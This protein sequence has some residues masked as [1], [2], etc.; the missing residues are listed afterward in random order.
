[1]TTTTAS[2][3]L[4]AANLDRSLKRTS[5]RPDVAR[6]SKYY[7]ANINKVKTVDD[8]LKNDRL[9]RF[10]MEAFGMSDMINSKAF[11]RKVLKEGTD[12]PKA[13]ANTLADGRYKE[14]AATFNF[15]RYASAT[16]AFDRVQQGTVDRY[17]RQQMEAQA[18]TQNEGVRLALY[19]ARKA[20]TLTSTY[21]ILAD[22]ALIKV[23]QTALD[24]PPETSM[25]RIEKQATMIEQ[26]LKIADFKDTAKLQ[27]FLDRFTSAWDIAND[28]SATASAAA[29]LG[30]STSFGV[31]SDVLASLQNLK[32]G[33]S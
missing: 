25:L 20:P 19:F 3:R 22:K 2:Y 5:T 10:A 30:G 26:R 32:L 31:S 15:A 16:T 24:I 1:M 8:F 12:A 11:M 18:G 28:T 29:V 17:V 33:G 27:H 6:E 21:G 4:I 23:V 14:F 7:L 13:F 9:Y